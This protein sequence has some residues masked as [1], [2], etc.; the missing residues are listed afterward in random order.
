MYNTKYKNVKFLIGEPF[1]LP[2]VKNGLFHFEKFKKKCG[3]PFN[4]NLT[5]T[6]LNLEF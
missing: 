4:Q 5:L 1:Q 3:K 6:Y 2:L